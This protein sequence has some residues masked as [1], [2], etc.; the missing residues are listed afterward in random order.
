MFLD[1]QQLVELTGYATRTKQCK[2]LEL[3][4]YKFDRRPSDGRPM[5]L[6]KQVEARQ[7]GVRVSI[8][9][10]RFDSLEKPA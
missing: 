5:L 1:D 9:G 7:L 4:G 2:A 6:L 3:M 10:P 8:R